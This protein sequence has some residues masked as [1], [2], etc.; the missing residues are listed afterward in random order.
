M[1]QP[2]FIT[3]LPRSRTA[4]WSQLTTTV[5]SLCHHEP[6]PHLK[7]FDA[8]KALWTHQ[9]WPYVGMSDA[10]LGFQISR[11]LEE[12][13]PRTLIVE[14]SVEDVKRSFL[15]FISGVDL[16]GFEVTVHL[17]KLAA[18]LDAAKSHPLVKVVPYAKLNDVETV[19]FLFHWLLRGQCDLSRVDTLMRLNIQVTRD[20]ALLEAKMKHSGWHLA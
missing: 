15:K 6:T 8:L 18:R 12:I 2:F 20:A 11:I 3:G 16:Q 9:Q 1:S 19:K 7:D 17:N 14:R 13:E 5:A 10:A 4:W